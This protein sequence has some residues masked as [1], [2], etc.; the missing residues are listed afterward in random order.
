VINDYQFRCIMAKATQDT[1][2]MQPISRAR[3]CLYL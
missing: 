1:R 3:W 2:A